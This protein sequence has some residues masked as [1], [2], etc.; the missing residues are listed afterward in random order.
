[1]SDPVERCDDAA[2][3][4]A[5]GPPLLG[6]ARGEGGRGHEGNDDGPPARE[7][8]EGQE[9]ERGGAGH[10]RRRARSAAG[11]TGEKR[12]RDRSDW[13]RTIRSRRHDGREAGTGD[14]SNA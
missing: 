14:N 2:V 8:A 3:R 1:M 9:D 5:P 10:G 11:G 12:G 4:I 6:Q 7:K 13:R